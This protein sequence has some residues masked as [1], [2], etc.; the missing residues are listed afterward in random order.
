MQ[1]TFSLQLWEILTATKREF[2]IVLDYFVLHSK[3]T[4]MPPYSGSIM[5]D[6]A[7]IPLTDHVRRTMLYIT[8]QILICAVSAVSRLIIPHLPLRY[9]TRVT[10]NS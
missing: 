3:K 6:P 4:L 8:Y 7:D 2:Q 1:S 9:H 10:S 5:D